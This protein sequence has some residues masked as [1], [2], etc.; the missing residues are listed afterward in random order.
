M[1]LTL[2][3]ELIH[4]HILTATLAAAKMTIHAGLRLTP[5]ANVV[6][7]KFLPP[8]AACLGAA[9]LAKWAHEN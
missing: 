6:A 7:R 3:V 1:L 4:F 9:G 2:L 8:F 5:F